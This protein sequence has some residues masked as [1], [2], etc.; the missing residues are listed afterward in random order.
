MEELNLFFVE[1]V[2]FSDKYHIFKEKV[3]KS[4]CGR[5]GLPLNIK[6]YDKVKVE[7]KE[8][9]KRGSD[10]KLCFKKAGLLTSPSNSQ[11]KTVVQHD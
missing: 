8:K 10:C 9:F 6:E 4:L 7:G 1:V 11:D 5:Y 3:D 2:M